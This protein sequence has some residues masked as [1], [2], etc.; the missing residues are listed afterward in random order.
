MNQRKEKKNGIN[1]KRLRKLAPTLVKDEQLEMFDKI[2]VLTEK[3]YQ[4]LLA[5]FW[6]QRE[7]CLSLVTRW[8]S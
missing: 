7:A 5:Y 2:Y 4:L 6:T 1:T 8:V 3:L